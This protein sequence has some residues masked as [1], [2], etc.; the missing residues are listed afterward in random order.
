MWYYLQVFELSTSS[1]AAIPAAAADADADANAAAAAAAAAAAD[2][3]EAYNA[4]DNMLV[5][6]R[7]SPR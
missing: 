1:A 5:D 4:P 7:Y 3:N 2:D 6:A